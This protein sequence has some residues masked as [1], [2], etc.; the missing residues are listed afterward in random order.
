MLDIDGNIIFQQNVTSGLPQNLD[1]L[2]LSLLNQSDCTSAD[3]TEG[4]E[5]WGECYSIENTT[6]LDLHGDALTGPIPPE[7]G[8]LTNVNILNLSNNQ[9]TGEIPSEIWNLTTLSALFLENNQLIGSI[10][11]II[12]NMAAL[13]ELDLSSNQLTGEIPQ[14]ICDLEIAWDV[15][16]CYDFVCFWFDICICGEK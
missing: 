5:L 13:T 3:G 10:P 9:L 16:D 15:Q 1:S 4:V 2:I 12:G 7:I 8:N 14:S 6:E 11:Q